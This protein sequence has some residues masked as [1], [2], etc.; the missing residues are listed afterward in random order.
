[1][2]SHNK[3]STRRRASRLTKNRCRRGSVTVEIAFAIPLIVL[4]VMGAIE[5]CNMIHLKQALTEAAYQ[6]ALEGI[7]SSATEAS[8]FQEI[9]TVLDAR[10]IQGTNKAAG[11]T[12]VTIENVAP[13]QA[14]F[15]KVDADT[16]INRLGLE[17]FV[18]FGTVEVEVFARKQ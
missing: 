2:I 3:K 6:G 5:S 13:G 11:Q 18:D 8:V 14:F 9:Q 15:V 10:N 7:K 17:R 12:G 4:V 16:S 1:M